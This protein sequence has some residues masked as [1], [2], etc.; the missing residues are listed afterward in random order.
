LIVGCASAFIACKTN[1][2][3]NGK[4]LSLVASVL[5]FFL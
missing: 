2:L 1:A 3:T 5:A 4:V